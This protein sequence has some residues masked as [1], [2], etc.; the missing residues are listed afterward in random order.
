MLLLG[1]IG[2]AIG[3]QLGL[4]GKKLIGA[5]DKPKIQEFQPVT[6]PKIQSSPS[7]PL[8]PTTADPNAVLK[9][10]DQLKGEMQKK[11][12]E[13]QQNLQPQ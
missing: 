13:Q 4:F 9:G 10:V 5:D 1:L 3:S 8:I 6:A 2:Y 12:Q 11:L 7:T